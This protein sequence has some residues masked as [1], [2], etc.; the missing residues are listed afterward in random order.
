MIEL[1]WTEVDQVPVVWA[2]A[3]APLRAGLLFR[4]GRA[5]ETLATSGRTHLIEHLAFTAMN[6]ELHRHDGTVDGTTTGFFTA[7]LP[8]DVSDFL[9]KVCDA[10]SSL[11]AERLE[12][13]KQVL[14]AENATRSHDVCSQ[15]LTWRYGAVGHG[16]AGMAELGLRTATLEQL[17]AYAAQ[18]FTSGNAV[19][20]LTGPPPDS[21]RL[22]LPQG[23]KLPLPALA[24]L[25]D[26]FPGWFLDDNSGGVAVGAT[27]PRALASTI[28]AELALA[29]LRK[30]LR[31]EQAVSYAPT[32]FYIPLDAE[33][34]HLVLYADSEYDRRAELCEAF[35]EVFTALRE[36]EAPEVESVCAR[37]AEHRTGVLAPPP[38]ARIAGEAHR[39]AA[40]WIFG[41]PFEAEES[42]DAQLSAATVEDVS[43][44]ARRVQETAIFAL[45]AE[46]KLQPWCGERIPASSMPLVNG[47]ELPHLEAPA[48]QARLVYGPDGVSVLLADGSHCTVRYSH[49]AATLKYEDGCVSLIGTDAAMVT[50][51]P[52]IWHDGRD[53]CYRILQRVPEHLL[54]GYPARPAEAIP[55]ANGRVRMSN[56]MLFIVVYLAALILL[57][58]LI[59]P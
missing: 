21:L 42:L 1:H 17:Q 19:L 22:R 3:G 31:V 4:A 51:E 39:A 48:E 55:V 24:P 45:P 14:A 26:T 8:G 20:W 38:A 25:Q 57:N 7:G 46:A 44:V 34:A 40:D 35:G 28:F 16:L 10:L 15:L 41:M 5:D 50:V 59:G 30:R 32:V 2:D 47:R 27:V 52:T 58:F 43:A 13:E 54:I 11:P 33:T 37:I 29:R 9:A 6:D 18:R 49:L 23:P 36:I 12:N 53:A 56:G